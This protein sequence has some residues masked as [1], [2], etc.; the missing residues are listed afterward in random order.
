MEHDLSKRIS[1]KIYW[2]CS[3][4]LNMPIP[5]SKNSSS[6]QQVKIK[7][8]TEEKN[9][10]CIHVWTMYCIYNGTTRYWQKL[11]I[12]LFQSLTVVCPGTEKKQ[13]TF[14]YFLPFYIKS[15]ELA[16]NC[17]LLMSLWQIWKKHDQ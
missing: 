4:Y 5:S 15:R 14:N 10:A 1:N 7:I 2:E 13:S 16:C 6:L 11:L 17:P 8:E 3:V 12:T 9:H